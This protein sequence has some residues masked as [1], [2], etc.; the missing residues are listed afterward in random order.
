[1]EEAQR[2]GRKALDCF[3]AALLAMTHQQLKG[4]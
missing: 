3:V 4:E 2:Q 1:M